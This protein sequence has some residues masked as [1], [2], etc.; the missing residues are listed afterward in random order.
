M[1]LSGRTAECKVARCDESEVA[2][3]QVR[4]KGAVAAVMVISGY[5]LKLPKDEGA[6]NKDVD[7]NKGIV[8]KYLV[9][10]RG[11]IVPCV[12]EVNLIEVP[13]SPAAISARSHS[14]QSA[15]LL[16]AAAP[17]VQRPHMGDRFS[18]KATDMEKQN[19]LLIISHTSAVAT[20]HTLHDRQITF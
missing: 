1:T 10:A 3:E 7:G 13:H 19:E 2:D 12:T 11:R 4:D 15:L 17:A 18:P 16:L 14:H 5:T 20:L 6:S 9:Y 8:T